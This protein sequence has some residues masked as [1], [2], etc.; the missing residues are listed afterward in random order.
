MF[1]TLAVVVVFVLAPFA[2]AHAIVGVDDAV[3][4]I[5]IAA[6]AGCGITFAT[7]GAFNS[8]E[9]FVGELLNEYAE[10]NSTTVFGLTNGLQ[11]NSNKLGQILLNNRWLTL[12]D[13]FASWLKIK[14]NLANNSTVNVQSGETTL[15]GLTVYAVPAYVLWDA[16]SYEATIMTTATDA[17]VMAVTTGSNNQNCHFE[18]MTKSQGQIATWSQRNVNTN[19]VFTTQYNISQYN[20]DTGWYYTSLAT[21]ATVRF[22]SNGYQTYPKS[23]FDAAIGNASNVNE[24]DVPIDIQTGN[25]TLPSEMPTYQTGDGAILDVG[26]DWTTPYPN[27]I[28]GIPET[29]PSVVADDT[30]I[31]LVPELEADIVDQVPSQTDIENLPGGSSFGLP[32]GFG[33]LRL[34]DIWHYVHQWVVDTSVAGG[35]LWN[36]ANAMASPVVNMVF[37][38]VVIAIVFGTLK[39]LRSH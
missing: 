26:A 28:D 21:M 27:V 34:S 14:Y 20:S 19:E 36:T 10:D 37:A 38:M 23:V 29:W 39:H 30:V 16:F 24:G 6:L 8:I 3:I 13:G 18:I 11:S 35:L 5:L 2:T 22:T 32:V 7:T 17:V 4:V 12:I 9:D 33:D 31:T 25:V 15:G 1:L